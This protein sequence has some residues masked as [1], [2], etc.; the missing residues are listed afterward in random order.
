MAMIGTSALRL[1]FKLAAIIWGAALTI[2][3]STSALADVGESRSWYLGNDNC[4][5]STDTNYG[6]NARK[7][8]VR[9][10]GQS[11]SSIGCVTYP[12]AAKPYWF[13]NVNNESHAGIDLKVGSPPYPI[14]YSL[15][16]G[17]V[18]DQA[19][20]ANAGRSTLVIESSI[21]GTKY[22]I[23]YLHCSEHFVRKDS[24]VSKGNPIC[25]TGS[26]GA[27]A[28]HLHI[29]AKRSGTADFNNLR[30]L[31]GS[32]CSGGVC[33]DSSIKSLYGLSVAKIE[34]L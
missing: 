15:F 26:V 13:A 5:R 32:H 12:W 3:S 7:L 31:S 28:P 8:A 29:E 9:A 17:M 30:A 11:S 18:V 14:A 22:R 34:S 4:Y 25:R 24:F 33:Y 27:T 6:E 2:C 1:K 10:L 21:S 19:L 20:D 23:Y 16:D